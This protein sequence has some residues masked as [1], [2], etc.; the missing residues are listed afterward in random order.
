MLENIP[1]ICVS[2]DKGTCIF[3][4]LTESSG[5]LSYAPATLV[6]GPSGLPG[7]SGSGMFDQSSFE[8]E[9]PQLV[10]VMTLGTFAD[11][12]GVPSSAGGQR[13]SHKD[14]L[15]AGALEADA[16]AR[17]R[18]DRVAGGVALAVGGAHEDGLA[19]LGRAR[20]GEARRAVDGG[21]ARAGRRLV[22]G[23]RTLV[24][25]GAAAAAR[26]ARADREDRGCTEREYRY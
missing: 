24:D 17:G 16:G 22:G 18:A 4:D 13:V 26:E 15:V 6:V 5:S 14:F 25:G 21:V 9:F 1:V 2:D 10:A 3:D 8:T 7:D 23:D 11:R 20:A 19:D 12:S